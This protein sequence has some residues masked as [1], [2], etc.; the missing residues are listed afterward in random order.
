MVDANRR[1]KVYRY[2]FTGRL[3][4]PADDGCTE[5]TLKFRT[6]SSDSWQWVNHDSSLKN[7]LLCFQPTK[8]PGRLEDYLQGT[9]TSNIKVHDIE[10]EVPD[11]RLWRLATTQYERCGKCDLGIPIR[12]ERWFSLVR[13]W[14]PWLAPRHGPPKED[15]LLSSFLRWDGLHLVILPISGM[16]DVLGILKPNSEGH[17]IWHSKRDGEAG[18]TRPVTP[19]AI[20]GAGRTFDAAIATVMHEARKMV[21]GMRTMSEE[22]RSE[23][24]T[25]IDQRIK[26]EWMDN[27]YDG[28]TYCTWNA[29]GQNLNQQKIFDALDTLKANDIGITNLIIDDNWQSLDK[30]GDSQFK[31]GMTDFEANKEGFPKGL[32]FTVT[33]IRDDHPNIRH[34]AVWHALFGYWGGISP[35]GSIAKEYKTK[36]VR[37]QD[38]IAGGEMTVVDP[39]DAVSRI[40][41]S[42]RYMRDLKH[43]SAVSGPEACISAHFIC[44]EGGLLT[45]KLT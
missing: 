31:R 12:L 37:K 5:F 11:T 38:G 17:V 32:K 24:E 29:L 19:H 2:Y 10:S 7:G 16:G 35:N 27:W 21:S 4:R 36:V 14:S 39:D 20:V 22:P 30:S 25:L 45:P 42:F 44:W 1:T 43:V 13:I 33:T 15:A 6:S 23:M 41:V 28:L 9:R 3:L 8:L 26:P 18:Y 34:V 40:W